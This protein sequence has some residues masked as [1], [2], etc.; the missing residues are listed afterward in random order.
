[1]RDRN[2]MSGAEMLY[3]MGASLNG[4][5]IDSDVLC[6]MALA[7]RARTMYSNK[8]LLND[9]VLSEYIMSNETGTGR[10]S[11]VFPT[12]LGHT[13]GAAVGLYRGP[14]VSKTAKLAACRFASC[15]GRRLC[16][17]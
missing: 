5:N 6:G 17:T 8:A 16:T 12:R 4:I 7:W 15:G 1:M 3:Q 9:I 10:R 2:S 13:S 11:A 14:R